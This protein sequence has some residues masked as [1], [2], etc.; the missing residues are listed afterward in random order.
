M[1]FSSETFLE[2][3]KILRTFGKKRQVCGNDLLLAGPHCGHTCGMCV[4]V[5][6][7]VCVCERESKG[8][9]L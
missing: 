5:C 7:C 8:R 9:V 3:W 1:V 2:V 4:C 6:V